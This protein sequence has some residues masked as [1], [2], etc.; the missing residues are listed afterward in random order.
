MIPPPPPVSS[1]FQANKGA[2]VTRKATIF[3]PVSGTSPMEVPGKQIG[4]MLQIGNDDT[5]YV[6][7]WWPEMVP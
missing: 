6:T 3:T 7:L 1:W 2:G 5:N 4:F